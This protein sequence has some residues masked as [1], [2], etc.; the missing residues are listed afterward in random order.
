[1]SRN[2]FASI[3]NLQ[4]ME[5]QTLLICTMETS[6]SLT[7]KLRFLPKTLDTVWMSVLI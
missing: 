3:V 7:E 6:P 2:L 4:A 1:M 5:K